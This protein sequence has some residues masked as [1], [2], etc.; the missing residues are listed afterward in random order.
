[1]MFSLVRNIGSSIGISIMSA[2][3]VRNAQ[4]N[5]SELSVFVNPF[6]PNLLAQMPAAAAGDPAT[7]SRL[8]GLV[9]QQALM[10]SYI[11]DFKLMMIVTIC[12]IPLALILRKPRPVAAL[13]GPAAAME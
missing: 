2:F 1:S 6:N 12:A 9:N 8:D 3:L 4:I 11:N 5:H 7:L 10:I 13:G